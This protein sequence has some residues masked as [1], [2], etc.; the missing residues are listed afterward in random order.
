MLLFMS[1]LLIVFL[2]L[3][4]SG[5]FLLSL[6]QPTQLLPIFYSSCELLLLAFLLNVGFSTAT[7]VISDVN[8]V[9]VVVGLPACC[10][11]LYLFC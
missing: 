4:V 2:L 9:H 11:R 6:L 1:L 3:L 7:A 10:C 8:G 5:M